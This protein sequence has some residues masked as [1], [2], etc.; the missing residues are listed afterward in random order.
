MFSYPSLFVTFLTFTSA[1]MQS[2]SI[3]TS[4]RSIWIMSPSRACYRVAQGRILCMNEIRKQQQNLADFGNEWFGY[5]SSSSKNGRRLFGVQMNYPFG[6]CMLNSSYMSNV[7]LVK[8]RNLIAH[9]W[10]RWISATARIYSWRSSHRIR[11]NVAFVLICISHLN[12]WNLLPR[13]ARCWSYHFIKR[14][15]YQ[16]ST[17]EAY[18]ALFW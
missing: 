2:R 3:V 16:Y 18:Q 7:E 1:L 6:K 9:S 5:Y 15:L 13:W 8:N 10:T 4:S 17:Q 12:Q 14:V 11:L